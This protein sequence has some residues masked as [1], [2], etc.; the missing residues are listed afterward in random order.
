MHK[1]LLVEQESVHIFFC[2]VLWLVRPNLTFLYYKLFYGC[3]AWK[4]VKDKYK[5]IC[6][7]PFSVSYFISFTLDRSSYSLIFYNYK[8]V[9]VND[10]EILKRLRERQK[11]WA[12]I[13]PLL[14]IHML[15]L[16]GGSIIYC[17]RFPSHHVCHTVRRALKFLSF[18]ISFVIVPVTVCTH[19][20]EVFLVSLDGPCL[21]IQN[22]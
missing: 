14:M 13:D 17:S 10:I 8:P 2:L 19:R 5:K 11:A 16:V 7:S 9:H 3:W 4:P 15:V 6:V 1:H 12:M 20:C 22:I 18:S 21:T